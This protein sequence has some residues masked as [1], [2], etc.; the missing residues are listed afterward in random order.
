MCEVESVVQA[1]A[2]CYV[3]CDVQSTQ[4]SRLNKT[5]LYISLA[6]RW[7]TSL[8]P[9]HKTVLIMSLRRDKKKWLLQKMN[10]RTALCNPSMTCELHCCRTKEATSAWLSAGWPTFP[11]LLKL[12]I[13]MCSMLRFRLLAPDWWGGGHFKINSFKKWGKPRTLGHAGHSY[14]R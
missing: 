13:V 7:F 10:F 12:P 3:R 4:I 9:H 11:R 1:K 6:H 2:F 14:T 5:P 8:D